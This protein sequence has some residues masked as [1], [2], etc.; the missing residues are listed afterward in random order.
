MT[1]NEFRQA[2]QRGL[3]R[4]Y[5]YVKES[6]DHDVKDDLLHYCLHNPCYDAQCEDSRADWLLSIIALT[7]NQEF[8]FQKIIAGLIPSTEWNDVAHLYEF[9]V[10]LAKRGIAEAK[11]AVYKK[12][13]LQEFNDSWL[14][15]SNLIDL[16]GI[17]GLCHVAKRI[18]ERL[19]NDGKYWECDSLFQFAS[20]QMG[21]AAVLEA[22]QQASTDNLFI[23]AYLDNSLGYKNK[24]RT[25]N[26][27]PASELARKRYNFKNILTDI[28]ELGGSYPGRFRAFGKY[29]TEEE[30]RPVYDGF[31]AETRKNQL[32]RY[33]WVFTWREMSVLDEKFFQLAM[34]SD[35]EIQEAAISA[36]K[37]AKAPRI[38]ELAIELA[39][40][41]LPSVQAS[42]IE[43]F[44]N[45][46]APGDH[47]TIRSMLAH[48]PDADSLHSACMDVI[49]IFENHTDPNLLGNRDVPKLS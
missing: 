49:K 20:Q 47:E 30:C 9:C 34:S 37:N 32:I 1:K 39:K 28:E 13:D 17:T 31:L 46:Y 6:G 40:F 16:D 24:N 3:G 4:A 7:K 21:E 44:V 19:I 42:A 5:L 22:L 18:G 33:L 36:L 25:S 38:R 29:A 12:F 48:T 35:I 8:Y 23:K 27:E 10:I 11:S 2:L 15:G 26:E 43:L 41:P 14:G 45:N